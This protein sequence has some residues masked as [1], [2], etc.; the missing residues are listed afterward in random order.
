MPNS[1]FPSQVTGV[2]VQTATNG[3][4]SGDGS[5]GNKL[6]VGVDGVTIQVNGSN[7]LEAI[8]SGGAPPFTV[9]NGDPF[10]KNSGT[11]VLIA[12]D[13]NGHPRMQDGSGVSQFAFATDGGALLGSVLPSLPDT[14][15]ASLSTDSGVV[16]NGTH[17][18][19][20][21]FVTA[22]G[23]SLPSAASN[24][25]TVVDNS[26]DGRVTVSPLPTGPVG[27]TA[28][29]LYMTAAGDA[30]PWKFA[31]TVANNTDTSTTV[32]VAD[33]ALGAAA[34]TTNTAV[35]ASLA[36]NGG[37]AVPGGAWD[38]SSAVITGLYDQSLNTIDDVKFNSVRVVDSYLLTSD[39]GLKTVTGSSALMDNNGGTGWIIEGV[40]FTGEEFVNLASHISTDQGANLSDFYA[41]A[42]TLTVQPVTQHVQFRGDEITAAGT[43]YFLLYGN[44]LFH[45]DGAGRIGTTV[46]LTALGTDANLPLA[47]TGA[48]TI[49]LNSPVI[50]SAL[51]PSD[52][53]VAGQLYSVAG[54]VHVSAG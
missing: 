11:N 22:L 47:A 31:K 7:Q 37:A 8:S 20:V 23:E 50:A 17:S 48:G 18:V 13:G 28:R 43:N 32:N 40:P 12:V 53:M 30:P 36:S 44:D 26:D 21:T 3:A 34:P 54:V 15:T 1:G 29:N 42:P 45:V 52:P 19:T 38:F 2:T 9:A 41:L 25:V 5:S 16:T 33:G 6:A 4:L 24:I 14:P 46:G 27:T 49:N 39:L 10:L 51:P 35:V